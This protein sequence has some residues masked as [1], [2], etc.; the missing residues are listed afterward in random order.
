[1]EFGERV[2]GIP[3]DWLTETMAYR[4]FQTQECAAQLLQ[5]RVLA[6][7]SA[8]W[9]RHASSIRKFV[10]F[11]K[12]RDV[13][14][15]YS[16]PYVVNLFLLHR[17]QDGSSFGG[18]ESFID[19]LSFVLRFYGI[20]N[21]C[22]DP[23]IKS[24]MKFAQKSCAHLKNEKSPFGSAEVRAIWDAIDSKYGGIQNIPKNVLRTF[25]LAVFQHQTF[26]R[27]SDVSKITL[28]DLFHDVDYFKIHI[29]FS[30]TDQGGEGQW[31]FLPKSDSLFR[32][33][34][35]LLCLYIKRMD[36][37]QEIDA[38]KLYLFPPLK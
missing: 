21:F 19:G 18:L 13:N 35:M 8:T 31:V 38:E 37:P 6:Y 11:C 23:M 1:M 29:R 16:T 26:A 32:D 22:N 36:F 15:F 5:V 33:S 17:V 14:L 2:L 7:S 20:P 4:D 3:A 9:I 24:V 25:M 12:I 30:K 10:E 27:Y 34:H 28:A